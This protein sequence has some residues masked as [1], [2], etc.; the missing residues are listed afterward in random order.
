[1][2][3]TASAQLEQQRECSQGTKAAAERGA[4]RQTSHVHQALTE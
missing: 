2:F 3:I 4:V 1:M